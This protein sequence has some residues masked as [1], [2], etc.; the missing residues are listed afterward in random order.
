MSYLKKIEEF[1]ALMHA[2]QL[3]GDAALSEI[4][5]VSLGYVLDRFTDVTPTDL[6]ANMRLHGEMNAELGRAY[7]VLMAKKATPQTV[8][9]DFSPFEEIYN[10][11]LKAVTGKSFDEWKTDCLQ[12][13]QSYFKTKDGQTMAITFT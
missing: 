13:I 10:T 1:N 12:A 6:T 5:K 2:N 8:Y 11:Q 3:D 4:E 9:V 7:A